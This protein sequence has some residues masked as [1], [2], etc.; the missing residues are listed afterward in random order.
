MD[1]VRA[2]GPSMVTGSRMFSHSKKS[3]IEGREASDF[4]T[5]VFLSG[6]VDAG[7]PVTPRDIRARADLRVAHAQ[8]VPLDV[9]AGQLATGVELD[10]LAQIE[11]DL[12][13][14]RCDV[15]AFGQ[16]RLSFASSV[17]LDQ[18]VVRRPYGVGQGGGALMAVEIRH[19]G[20]RREAECSAGL[21]L[22]RSRLGSRRTDDCWVGGRHRAGGGQQ[23]G[24]RGHSRGRGRARREECDAGAPAE[25]AHHLATTELAHWLIHVSMKVKLAG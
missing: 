2:S 25:N 5:S 6:V 18:A 7:E 1:L 17:V 16:H 4:R 10:A 20:S 22:P 12:S 8:D 19:V 15:P 13:V 23:R 21:G 3:N 11:L 9:V 24:G 14:V